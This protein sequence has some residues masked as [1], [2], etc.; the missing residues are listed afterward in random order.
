MTEAKQQ[1]WHH[2]ASMKLALVQ[3]APVLG[4]DCALTVGACFDDPV[5]MCSL[6]QVR[7]TTEAVIPGSSPGSSN[8]QEHVQQLH[9]AVNNVSAMSTAMC[10]CRF[11]QVRYTIEAVMPGGSASSSGQEHVQ[12][13]QTV[14]SELLST[15]EG[16]KAF[17]KTYREVKHLW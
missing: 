13:L 14:E 2:Q 4:S 8:S 15:R 5:C 11:K 7:Y 17:E 6:M 16:L 1:L 3:H 10:L 9:N 12:Q